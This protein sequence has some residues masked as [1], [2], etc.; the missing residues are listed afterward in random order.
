MTDISWLNYWQLNGRYFMAVTKFRP[1]LFT[2]L[3]NKRMEKYIHFILLVRP[4]SKGIYSGERKEVFFF[5]FFFN[6]RQSKESFGLSLIILQWFF[7]FSIFHLCMLCICIYA[8]LVCVWTHVWMCACMCVGGRLEDD[9]INHL[10]KALKG[11]RFYSIP[12]LFSLSWSYG[13][14]EII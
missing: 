8:F 12:K 6:L 5:V 4:Y 1:Q 3:V 13:Y 10:S 2:F 14:W 9:V 7:S 11:L